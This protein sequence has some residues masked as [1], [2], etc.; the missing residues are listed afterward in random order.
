MNSLV[1]IGASSNVDALRDRLYLE[2]NKL[3]NRGVK[4]VLSTREA[5]NITFLGCD[6]IPSDRSSRVAENQRLAFRHYLAQAVSD[7][8]VTEWERVIL[9]KLVNHQKNYFNPDERKQILKRAERYL[10]LTDGLIIPGIGEQQLGFPI[11]CLNNR[12][13]KIRQEVLEYLHINDELVIDGFLRFR[14][15]GYINQL[16]QA[17]DSAIDELIMER[18][19]QDF[20]RLLQY[21]VEIQE[22]RASQV[23]VV[24]KPTGIFKIYDSQGEPVDNEYQDGFLLDVIDTDLNYEDL[25]ISA[26]IT[27][28]PQQITIHQSELD[29]AVVSIDTIQR[30]FDGRVVICK[31]CDHCKR[32]RQ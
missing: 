17:V 28:A 22:P 12:C 25:L 2:S 29:R 19:Y 27:I 11:K 20:I 3:Q 13:N 6:L 9:S 24:L 7:L 23:H 31:G 30:V 10:E 4:L 15:K 32:F 14:L 1:S 18:E 16:E 5:G 21:F 8:I 26:L